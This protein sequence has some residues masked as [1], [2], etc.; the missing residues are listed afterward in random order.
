MNKLDGM[1]SADRDRLWPEVVF[2]F[3]DLS[4]RLKVR[5]RAFSV[6]NQFSFPCNLHVLVFLSVRLFNARSF[7]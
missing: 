5:N 6:V 2:G 4:K 3:K 7:S 1:D